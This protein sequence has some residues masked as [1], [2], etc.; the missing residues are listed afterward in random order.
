MEPLLS[1]DYLLQ[2]TVHK[3][4]GGA[5]FLPGFQTNQGC[6][7]T[8]LQPLHLLDLIN[9][10]LQDLAFV[11][12]DTQSVDVPNV[13]RQQLCQLLQIFVLLLPPPLF[14]AVT[15][16]TS[17]RCHVN[18]SPS[19]NKALQVLAKVMARLQCGHLQNTGEFIQAFAYIHA[20]ENR[21]N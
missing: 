16:N 3:T 15:E 17:V 20:Y 19:L 10:L 21:Q 2:F 8:L 9:R 11:W 1:H 5:L 12:F 14:I 4:L 6:C 13:C 7:L 18:A